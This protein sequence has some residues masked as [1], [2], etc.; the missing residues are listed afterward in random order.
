MASA[1]IQ[2]WALV[3]SAYNYDIVFKPGSQNANANVLSRLPLADSPS[4]VPLPEET[5]LL[6]ENLQLSPITA[7]QIKIWTAH[8]PVLSQVQDLVLQGWTTTT[9]PELLPY[10]R[11]RDELSILDGCILWGNIII[12]H[13]SSPRSC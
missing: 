13:W 3:L 1:R 9:E 5:V 12:G 2:R 4:N 8:D 6:L 10:Q 11:R 7:A